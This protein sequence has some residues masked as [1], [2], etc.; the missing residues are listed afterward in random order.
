MY[1]N[2]IEKI[3]KNE[4]SEKEIE[5]VKMELTEKLF[6]NNSCSTNQKAQA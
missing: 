6:S 2:L 5:T 4:Y 3:S 1:F